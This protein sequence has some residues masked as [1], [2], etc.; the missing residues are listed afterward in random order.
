MVTPSINFISSSNISFCSLKLWSRMS[1]H[2]ELI[3]CTFYSNLLL[4]MA[5]TQFLAMGSHSVTMLQSIQA[6]KQ[7][8]KTYK[9]STKYF[10]ASQAGLII[11]LSVCLVHFTNHSC[12]YFHQDFSIFEVVTSLFSYEIAKISCSKIN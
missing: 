8:R 11:V 4:Y 2:L 5:Q 7:G 3:R 10:L 1:A 6:P 9:M 12:R